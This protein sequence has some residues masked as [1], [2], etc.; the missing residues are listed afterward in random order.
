MAATETRTDHYTVI[1][2]DTHAGGSHAA[3]REYLDEE[4]RDEF[5]AW[6]GKYKNPYKDLGDNRR[7]R[8]WDNDM[9]NNA[10]LN[11]EGVVGEVVFPNTVPPFFPSFVLFAQPPTPEQYRQRRAG[12]Q[13]HNR[14]LKDFCDEYPERRAGVGQIFL[15]DVDDAI[16]DAKWIKENGL[17]GGILLP[18]IPPDVKWVKPLYDPCYEPLWDVLEDLEIPVNC[19]GG[20]G[21]P[22]YGKYP[23]SMLLYINEVSFYSQRPMVQMMLSAVFERHP[24]L[25]FVLTELGAAW[26]PGLLAQLDKTIEQIRTTGETG[27]IKYDKGTLPTMLASEMWAQNGWVGCAGP[28]PDDIAARHEIG[29][30]RFMWGSDYPHDEGTHPHTKNHL[31]HRFADIDHEECVKMLSGNAARLYGF[32]LDALAPLANQYGLT[33]EELHT[34]PEESDAHRFKRIGDDMDTDA[35]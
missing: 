29:I 7:L 20:T 2:A 6:R 31:R 26:I 14:W 9:R 15:N 28:G 24:K 1:S 5:D 17:R 3:Y 30:D 34:L 33:Y 16:E 25:N 19:H 18:N 32:D 22:D 8:N 10:Q 13:A 21:S 4:F 23:I 27:E 11:D 12:V 35:L